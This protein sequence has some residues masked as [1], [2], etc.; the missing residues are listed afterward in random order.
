M[1]NSNKKEKSK[2]EVQRW[3]SAETN[4]LRLNFRR[5]R[6]SEMAEHLNRSIFSVCNKAQV[7]KL[8]KS[9]RWTAEE[10]DYVKDHVNVYPL[11][12]IAKELFRQ[13]TAVREM[14]KRE[15]IRITDEIEMTIK[16]VARKIGISECVLY[17]HIGTGELKVLG[18]HVGASQSFLF[19]LNDVRDFIVRK[20]SHRRFK[21]YECGMSVKG[22]MYCDKH[23]GYEMKQKPIHTVARTIH[24]SNKNYRPQ[25]TKMLA[26]IRR[27]A[28]LNQSTVS[29][30][31]G[32]EESWY[33]IFERM[34][35][36]QITLDQLYDV[37]NV[38]GYD[39]EITF[40]KK[41]EPK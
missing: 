21:C 27:H 41:E 30:L 7:M 33:G 18:R 10:I 25:L 9:R 14:M 31:C 28:N 35:K 29:V 15:N 26:N 6:L 8:R 23:I 12:Q 20:M 13:V 40:K 39:Y 16:S 1:S 37:L 17:H 5:M 34:D 4:F 24:I 3:T 19:N 11:P 32:K 36:P 22:D 38:M 2:T